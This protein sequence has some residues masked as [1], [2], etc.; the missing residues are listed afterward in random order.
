[1]DESDLTDADRR[2]K[3]LIDL[4]ARSPYWSFSDGVALAYNLDPQEAVVRRSSGSD[5]PGI[6]GSADASHLLDLAFRAFHVGDLDDEAAPVAFMRWAR[7]MNVE[8]HPDWWAA[9]K[10]DDALAKEETKAPLPEKPAPE[11]KTKE[12]E[13]LLKMVAGMAV[14]GYGWDPKAR[15]SDVTKE[16]A[17]DLHR[18]GIALD[19]DTVRSWLRKAADLIPPQTD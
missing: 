10:N 11:L 4:W 1:M 7:S 12:R 13:S 18:A 5:V 16:I 14:G 9:V 8:F 6:R 17:D 3:R 2:R 15:R 19:P